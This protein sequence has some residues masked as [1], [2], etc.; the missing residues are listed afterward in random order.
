MAVRSEHRKNKLLS[1]ALARTGRNLWNRFTHACSEMY[2]NT[3]LAC[4]SHYMYPQ[5][6][7]CSRTEDLKSCQWCFTET[8]ILSK[9]VQ[10]GCS[11]GGMKGLFCGE[12]CHLVH[13]CTYSVP[14]MLVRGDTAEVSHSSHLSW[15]L[16]DTS[17]PWMEV[18]LNSI[19][20]LRSS[21]NDNK[22]WTA[23]WGS[24]FFLFI[25]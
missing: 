20:L 3:Q 2:S 6:L 18:S 13:N 17:S 14:G 5:R 11:K 7:Q 10:A 8:S 9:S 12:H 22:I 15:K 4:V 25:L 21:G 24:K 16:Q 1:G 23:F 19:S